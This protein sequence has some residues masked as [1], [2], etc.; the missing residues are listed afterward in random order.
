MGLYV[1]SA[2]LC[3]KQD[4]TQLNEC[5]KVAANSRT[6]A[7]EIFKIEY[8]TNDFIILNSDVYKLSESELLLIGNLKIITNCEYSDK[9]NQITKRDKLRILRY[10]EQGFTKELI[11]LAEKLNITLT[12]II[13]I[14]RHNEQV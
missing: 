12:R 13:S 14:I 6:E 4:K 1:V 9:I 3:T 8:E 2:I 10:Y 5:V 7:L 11:D